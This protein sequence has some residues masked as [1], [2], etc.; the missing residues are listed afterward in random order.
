MA[1]RLPRDIHNRSIPAFFPATGETQDVAVNSDAPTNAP[2]YIDVLGS[3]PTL[4]DVPTITYLLADIDCRVAVVAAGTT[5]ADAAAM[6]DE[7]VLIANTYYPVPCLYSTRAR[8][9]VCALSTAETG[10]LYAMPTTDV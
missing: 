1:S 3:A 10:T 5:F 6:A 9:A 4:P 7:F 8:I 2:V